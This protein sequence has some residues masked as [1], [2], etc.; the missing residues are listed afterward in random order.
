[1]KFQKVLCALCVL[2]G[3]LFT[4]NAQN[5]SVSPRLATLLSSQVLTNGQVLTV[6]T[7]TNTFLA[8]N[9]THAIPVETIITSTNN[10]GTTATVTNYFDLSLDGSNF[11]T[12]QPVTTVATCNGTNPV[13]SITF[14]PASSFDGA[15][16]IQLTKTGTGATNNITVTV[17]IG[18][19]P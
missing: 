13:R 17:R 5:L 4:A 9:F 14:V 15:V 10:V 12:T 19:V 18:A 8:F 1:M 6:S 7:K 16:S 3:F 11:T 2:C